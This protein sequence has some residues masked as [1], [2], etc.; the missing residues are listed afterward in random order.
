M[1]Q[2][3]LYCRGFTAP[4]FFTITG[5]VFM[6]LL[7]RN[8]VQGRKNPRLKKGFRRAVEL[9]IWGYLLRLSFVYL[10]TSGRLTKTFMRPDVLH[11]IG[12]GL[13]FSMLLY[14]LINKLTFGKAL[15][16]FGISFTIFITNP[17]YTDIVFDKLPLFIAAYLTK[18]NGAVFYLFPWLGYVFFGAGIAF[19]FNNKPKRLGFWALGFMAIGGLLS[20]Q[21]TSIFMQLSQIL[22][23]PLL[24][25]VANNNYLFIRLGDVLMLFGVFMLLEPWVKHSLWQKIG[26][27]TLSIYIVHYFILYGSLTGIGLYKFYHQSLSWEY[28]V[29]GAICF[30]MG[31]TALV[32]VYPTTL[33]P[34]LLRVK[35]QLWKW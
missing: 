14:L 19:L 15:L 2:I 23:A 13:L 25:Q 20:F 17:L 18:A 29:I 34:M 10:L 3:W 30:V 24:E 1:Y 4:V 21:S 5:W 7:Q 35:H 31:V 16:L 32:L 28:T 33:K 26:T 27:K 9:L 11:I 8:P 6:F 12:F 22:H